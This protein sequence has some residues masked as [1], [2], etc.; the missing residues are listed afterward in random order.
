MGVRKIIPVIHNVSSVQRLV[1]LA[2][3]VIALG[4]ESL[5]ATKVYG[6]AAQA[7]IPEAYRLLIKDNRG[8]VVLP[9]LRD[10]VEVFSPSTVLLVDK[11]KASELIDPLSPPELEGTVMVVL[12]GSDSSFA[13]QES[14][15]GRAIY[16]RGLSSRAGSTAE[17]SL[18]LYSLALIRQSSTRFGDTSTTI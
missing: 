13:P 15:L 5:V 2:K 3:I 4:L 14:V 16:I 10:A 12:N 7:G 6:A 17:A 11:E 9:E 8:L 1:D 18:L